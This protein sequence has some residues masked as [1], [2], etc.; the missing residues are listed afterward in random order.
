MKK[1][2]ISF[3]VLVI[4]GMVFLYF[5]ALSQRNSNSKWYNLG[6]VF[7]NYNSIELSGS[8]S[9]KAEFNLLCEEEE[10]EKRYLIKNGEVVSKP[11][12]IKGT[13]VFYSYYKDSIISTVY[14]P[15]VQDWWSF[16]YHF[17]LEVL[18]DSIHC[19]FDMDGPSKKVT[20]INTP[21]AL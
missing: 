15:K 21:M 2:I 9:L 6:S 12:S 7:F 17:K 13:A 19:T 3:G 8:D 20:V 5:V 16:D 18:N 11:R 10:N 1:I 4:I 14:Q